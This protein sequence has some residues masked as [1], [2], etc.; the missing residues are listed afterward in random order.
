[1]NDKH[2]IGY[3]WPFFRRYNTIKLLVFLLVVVVFSKKAKAQQALEIG[4]V[5]PQQE[6]VLL[7]NSAISLKFPD[8]TKPSLLIFWNASCKT[9][10]KQMQ[11]LDSLVK[12]FSE[13]LHIITL[14]AEEGEAAKQWLQKSQLQLSLPVVAAQAQLKQYFPHQ[15]HPHVVWFNAQGQFVATSAIDEL[16]TAHLQTFITGKMPAIIQKQDRIDFK[17]GK[18]T[19]LKE[20]SKTY[21][22]VT[23]Y[24]PGVEPAFKVWKDSSTIYT[25]VINFS[26][27][28]LYLM[29]INKF[30]GYPANQIIWEVADKSHYQ[31]PKEKALEERWKRAYSYCYESAMPLHQPASARLDKM[32]Q[33]L[34]TAL[35]LNVR[36]ESRHTQVWRLYPLGLIKAAAGGKAYNNFEEDTPLKQMRNVRLE[37][38]LYELNQREENLP[39]I[40]ETAFSGKLDLDLYLPKG[41]TDSQALKQAL[42]KYHIGMELVEREVPFLVFTEPSYSTKHLN[43]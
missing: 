39:F 26:S 1:M 5:L 35:H 22:I 40:D 13:Q 2:R 17:I 4:S 25:Q 9:T 15:L 33:D 11:R 32:R 8:L 6:L 42:E 31:F 14:T 10:Q 21:S 36:L 3:L 30:L 43:P 29:A 27:Y 34:N 12:P 7:S 28:T 20:P 37:A 19:L 16:T 38:L 18:S 23:P 41:F 24:I